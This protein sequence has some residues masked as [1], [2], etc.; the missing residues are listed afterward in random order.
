MPPVT[1]A[2][3]AA[4]DDREPIDRYVAAF[5]NA[6]VATIERLMRDDVE[7]EMPPA[8]TWFR[9]RDAVGAFLVSRAIEPY[10][11]RMVPIRANGHGA[12]ATYLGDADD[13][14]HAHSIQVCSV[15]N[16]RIAHI[17][18]FQDESLFPTF[19]LPTTVR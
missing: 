18:A 3:G 14:F 5:G 19:G 9:G 7:L 12:V 15:V 11:W 17:F 16:G 2:K 10:R 1:S 8:A 6:D 13:R 4:A